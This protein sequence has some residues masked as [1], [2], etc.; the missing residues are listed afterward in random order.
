MPG[1]DL[2]L[3]LP[4][5]ADAM[6]VWSAKILTALEAIEADLAPRIPAGSLDIS[7]NLSMGGAALTNVGGVRLSGGLATEVGTLYMEGSE[8]HV[9]TSAGPVQITLGGQLNIAAAGTIGGD[10][11]GANPAVVTYDDVSGE[12]RFLQDSSPTIQAHLSGAS[13]I[14][15]GATSGAVRLGAAA[16][17]ATYTLT[18]PAA[19]PAVQSL[20]QVSASG[21]LSG[22]NTLPVNESITLSGTGK[23]K[24]GAYKLAIPALYGVAVQNVGALSQATNTPGAI[25]AASSAYHFPLLGLQ[26]HWRV[27]SVQCFID[28]ANVPVPSASY[29]LMRAPLTDVFDGAGPAITSNSTSPAI[30]CTGADYYANNGTT[31]WVRVATGSGTTVS[32]R[33]FVVTYDVV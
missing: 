24:H 12:Y 10:Y 6:S 4:T 7:T 2:N 11:G 25:V 1:V 32:P 20:V 16:V 22:S 21:V 13:V 18:M 31:L 3:D 17:T 8:L 26:E 23:I 33:S 9:Y 30:D 29:F 19:L 5:L 15:N 28:T 27:R 14:L